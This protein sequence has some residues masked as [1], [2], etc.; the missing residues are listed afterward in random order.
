MEGIIEYYKELDDQ[1][2][3]N[4]VVQNTIYVCGIYTCLAN[5]KLSKS[6]LGDIIGRPIYVTRGIDIH[7]A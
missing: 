3:C 1:N 2:V 6:H 5:T 4:S 7:Y